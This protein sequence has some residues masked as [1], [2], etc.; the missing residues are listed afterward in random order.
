MTDMD[1]TV[2]I[3]HCIDT[4]GPLYEN[5][6]AKFDRVE[7]VL[8]I[9]G[10]EQSW[11]VYRRVQKG[12]I[13]LKGQEALAREVFSDHRTNYMDS[14]DKVNEMVERVSTE[15]FR[16]RQPDSLGNGYAISWFTLDLVEFAAN[17]RRRALGYHAIFDFYDQFLKSHPY[18]R[19]R[20]HWHFHPMSTYREAHRNGTSLLNSPHIW[21]T[22]ARRII[23]RRSFPSCVRSGFQTERPDTHW[24]LEQYIPFDFTNTAVQD[25][26]TIEE[27]ADLANGRFCDWRL[28]PSDWSVYRPSHDNYQLP[29][30]CRRW[31][32]RA[33]N[34]MNRFANLEEFEVEKAFARAESGKPT[35]MGVASHDWRDLGP[36]IDYVRNMV[37]KVQHNHPDVQYRYCDGLEAMRA[38][39]AGGNA[40]DPLE[41]SVFLDRDEGGLPSVLRVETRKGKVFGPQPFLAIKTRSQRFLHDNFDFSTDLKSWRYAF[42]LDSVRPDDLASV[43]VAANDSYGNTSLTVIDA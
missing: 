17:P 15:E 25:P 35:L 32:S 9:K 26:S 18:L 42:D 27:Q 34:V 38:V 33:L 1:K 4:E 43:G 21:E 13:D 24:F 41:L 31:I 36:E 11:D 7:A 39:A 10:L 14:W 28:A 37:A 16:M 12:E 5:L 20:L 6:E 2:Y 23:E 40:P 3:V 8:G 19:D 30:N 29:G 22:L